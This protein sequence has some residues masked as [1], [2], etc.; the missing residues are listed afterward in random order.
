MP[1]ATWGDFSS[2]DID[3]AEQRGFTPYA[4][5]LPPSGLYRF[6]VKQMKAGESNAGNP[7]IQIVMELDGTW[8][9]NHKKFNGCPLF[10]NMPVMK[11]T[12]FRV[13]AFC[14]AFGITSKEFQTRVITDEDGKITKLGSA[15][16]PAGLEVFVNVKRSTDPEYGERIQLNGTGYLPVADTDDDSDPGDDDSGG[17]S[18]DLDEAPF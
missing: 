2:N 18:D 7:K 14:E 15:G 8:K 9:P 3:S 12:A 1:K 11:S 17:D 5:D 13:R 4:G 10:D 6:V 16:D